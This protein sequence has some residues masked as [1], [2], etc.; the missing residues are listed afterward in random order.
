MC[1]KLT[2]SQK[3]LLRRQNRPIFK[4]MTRN[5][6]PHPIDVLAQMAGSQK[7]LAWILG[8]SQEQVSRWRHGKYPLPEWV[9]VLAEAMV[10][11]PPQQWPRRW[12]QR[13]NDQ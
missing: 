5:S 6:M 1:D 12:H 11:I 7:R 2:H 8:V 4:G 10:R 3:M 9:I 13:P